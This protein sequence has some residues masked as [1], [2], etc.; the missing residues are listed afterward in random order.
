MEAPTVQRLRFM[1]PTQIRY[2]D[3]FFGG[4]D[5]MMNAIYFQRRR[6]AKQCAMCRK[7]FLAYN[8]CWSKTIAVLSTVGKRAPICERKHSASSMLPNILN[9]LFCRNTPPKRHQSHTETRKW[10]L[11]CSRRLR[12]SQ[13]RPEIQSERGWFQWRMCLQPRPAGKLWFGWHEL[14]G[15]MD[16]SGITGDC[17]VVLDCIFCPWRRHERASPLLLG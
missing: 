2:I 1:S 10:K 14:H 9:E 7:P 17:R 6:R 16:C 5:I 4:A 12:A 11:P 13:G 3:R 8:A 15:R